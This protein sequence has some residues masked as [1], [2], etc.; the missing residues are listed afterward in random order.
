MIF[1]RYPS[2]MITLFS[3]RARRAF[4][5][6]EV[7]VAVG[8][9]AFVVIAIIGLLLPN[10]KMVDEKIES[11]VARRLAQNIQSELQR[12]A[13]TVAEAQKATA[14]KGF[15]DFENAFFVGGVARRSLFMIA[16]RDGSRVLVTG[17]D[18]Y[19]AWNDTYKNPYKP[20]DPT[21]YSTVPAAEQLTA[22]NNPITHTT[23]GNPPGIMFRD[24]YYLIEIFLP[25]SPAYRQTTVA[26]DVAIGFV[27]VSVRVV[28]P[29][30]L[31]DG[32]GEPGTATDYNDLASSVVPPARHSVFNFNLALTP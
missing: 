23:P 31:P 14:R 6:V 17:E 11:D 32:P 8:I 13:R 16:T 24:R 25:K 5:L 9:F 20:D 7:V 15:D 19:E 4:S 28:W 26:S 3:A 27:P 1:R 30:R 18:P 22:E 10:T 2:V 21:N 12:Y 29:Y